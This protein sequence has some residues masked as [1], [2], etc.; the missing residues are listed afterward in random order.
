LFINATPGAILTGTQREFCRTWPNQTE[1]TVP[2][3]HFVQED[4]PDLIGE[5]LSAWYQ[6]LTDGRAASG[7]DAE[8]VSPR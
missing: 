7:T 5:A 4:S 2:G 6:T 3:I 1:V 8:R